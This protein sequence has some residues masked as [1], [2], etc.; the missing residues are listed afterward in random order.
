[1]NKKTYKD[2]TYRVININNNT[3][4]GKDGFKNRTS[5]YIIRNFPEGYFKQKRVLDLGCASGAVLFEIMESVSHGIGVD[6]DPK[7]L[8]IGK[9]IVK[10]NDINNISLVEDRLENF[11]INSDSNFDC[12][13][14]LNIL[15]HLPNPYDIIKLVSEISDDLICVELPIHGFYLPYERDA[16]KETNF[17]KLDMSDVI[18]AFEKLNYTLESKVESDNQES[19][20]GPPRYI[21]IF[22]KKD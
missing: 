17:E 14:L 8:D 22:K 5:D 20:I 2:K 15:H 3:Y 21:C 1:M 6:V 10:E 7:K 4:S 13:F 12:I 11:I 18:D 9:E 16:H 19:F